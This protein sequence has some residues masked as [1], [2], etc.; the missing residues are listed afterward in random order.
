MLVDQGLLDA[1]PQLRIL[2]ERKSSFRQA[3]AAL[4]AQEENCKRAQADLQRELARLGPDWSCER[5]RATDRSLFAREDLEKQAREGRR[6]LSAPGCG[7]CAEQGQPGC[8]NRRAGRHRSPREFGPACPRRWPPCRTRPATACVRPW[9]GLKTTA[10]S[11]RGASAPCLP[12]RAPRLPAPMIPCAFLANPASPAR[13]P[14]KRW[15]RSWPAGRGP[16]AG[17]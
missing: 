6:G 12:T 5:I 3:L 11:W 17:R 10:A 15:T 2:S 14:A 16:D 4:P 7:G 8:G 9:P 13:N 1:L